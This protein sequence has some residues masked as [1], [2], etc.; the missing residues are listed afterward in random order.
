MM[1]VLAHKLIRF[2]QNEEGATLIEFALVTAIFIFL[3]FGLIDFARL[4]YSNVLAEKATEKAVRMAVVR[5]AACPGVPEVNQRSAAGSLALDLPNGSA[6]TAQAGLCEDPGPVTCAGSLDNGTVAAIWGRVRPLLPTGA[7]PEHLRFTYHFEP[8][9]NRVGAP[10]API[11]TVEIA[12]LQ[13]DFIS[14]LGA[15]AALSGGAKNDTLGDSFVFASMSA[16]LPAED[17]K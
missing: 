1:R 7:G 5:P 13:F 14:P 16:S 8:E 2:S 12:D 6:C 9:L 3:F 11:V 10:Y 17:L 4:G 15:L